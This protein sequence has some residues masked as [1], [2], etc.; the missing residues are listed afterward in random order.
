M[1]SIFFGGGGGGG[2]GVVSDFLSL[3]V[4]VSFLRGLYVCM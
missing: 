4:T 2:S 3:N 1:M